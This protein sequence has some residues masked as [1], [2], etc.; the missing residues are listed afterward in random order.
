MFFT[1][2]FYNGDEKVHNDMSE[3][4]RRAS[5][6]FNGTGTTLSMDI[7]NLNKKVLL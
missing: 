4:I 2:L 7:Y 3:R 1:V 5:P 6:T